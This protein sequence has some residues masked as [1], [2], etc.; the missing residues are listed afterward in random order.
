[1]DHRVQHILSLI[2]AEP[3]RKHGLAELAR[4]VSLSRAQVYLLFKEDHVGEPP[5]RHRKH[6]KM[7]Y[8][9]SLLTS[10]FLNVQEVRIRAGFNDDSHF[11]R[12]FKKIFAVTPKQYQ[13]LHFENGN[14]PGVN[15][16]G[17]SKV[18]RAKRKEQSLRVSVPRAVAT[19]STKGQE[20]GAESAVSV[21]RAV[22][23][24]SIKSQE[25]RTKVKIRQTANK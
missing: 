19:G 11:T 2:E 14:G 12:D 8:A 16:S 21:P 20:P 13:R 1:M 23:T 18:R 4:A 3:G 7:E 17:K 5:M 9:A 25:S 15:E 10:E 6:L 24:G 22:A